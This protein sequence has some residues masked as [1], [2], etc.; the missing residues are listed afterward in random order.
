MDR[1]L[2]KSFIS[3]TFRHFSSSRLDVQKRIFFLKK[4]R[5]LWRPAIHSSVSI[6][7]RLQL[8]QRRRLSR[9]V[10]II[11]HS[12]PTAPTGRGNKP[13]QTCTITEPAHEI[14]ALL[15]LRKLILQTRVY[16]PLS[17]LPLI[18]IFFNLAIE[19]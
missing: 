1:S 17:L 16:R 15:V 14:M 12:Q 4:K 11:D 6:H 5:L 13:H 19:L 10:T 18:V 2:C 3:S 8:L 9:Y 7:L